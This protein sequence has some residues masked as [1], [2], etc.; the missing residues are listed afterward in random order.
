MRYRCPN[1]RAI[2]T[3]WIKGY[4]LL[5]KG[6]KTGAYLTIEQEDGAKVP[7]AVWEVSEEDEQRLDIYEGTPAFYY[8]KEMSITYT[9]IRTRKE[10]AVVAFVYIMH[11]YRLLGIPSSRYVDIC[12]QGYATFGFD[13]KFLIEAYEASRKEAEKHAKKK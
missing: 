11:E 13:I 7:V 10:R 4:Q 8:K 6:S 1:A 2:G 9:G 5:F 3:A 12:R